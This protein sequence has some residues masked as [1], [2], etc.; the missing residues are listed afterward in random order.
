[1]KIF[2]LLGAVV[3][4]VNLIS[5]NS[6]DDARP[7]PM[8]MPKSLE[9]TYSTT[10]DSAQYIYTSNGKLDEMLYYDD[11]RVAIIEKLEYDGQGKLIKFMKQNYLRDPYSSY[12]F[13]YNGQSQIVRTDMWYHDS[14]DQRAITTFT[15]DSK[16]RLST[17]ADIFSITYY[18]YDEKD[19][20][21]KVF[22]ESLITGNKELGRENISFDDH[23]RFF[24]NVPELVILNTIVNKYEPS[25]NNVKS[26]IVHMPSSGIK[27]GQAKTYNY[28]LMYDKN[29]MV[30]SNS[31]P[32]EH[33]RFGLPEINFKNFKYNCQ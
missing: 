13:S 9:V 23:R 33:T 11:G 15:Y 29:G 31:V 24:A 4:I 10:F 14:D 30:I 32:W 5:C 3:L 21:A 19:N 2:S 8:C 18:E 12:E 1:M 7:K 16:G 22:Y 25:K 20:V 28:N 26:S 17:A 27:F 6:D